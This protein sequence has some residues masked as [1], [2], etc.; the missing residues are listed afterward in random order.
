M[1]VVRLILRGGVLRPP[2][3]PLQSSEIRSGRADR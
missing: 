1:V 2:D 3:L